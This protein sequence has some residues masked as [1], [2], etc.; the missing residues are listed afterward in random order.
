MSRSILERC[1]QRVASFGLIYLVL[2]VGSA[3]ISNDLESA[4]VQAAVR[5][6][7]LLVAVAVFYSH[8]RVEL[9]RS[10]QRLLVSAL[11]TSSAVALGTFLLAVYAV[12][13]SWW[14]SSYL[15][16]SLLSALLI[17][18]MVTS[19]PAFLVALVLGS[20]IARFNTRTKSRQTETTR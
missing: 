8:L 5:V 7:I 4:P 17:W 3:F 10:A 6:G 11:I 1:W 2:G 13:L 15:P 18:P 12:G 20:L 14:E 19:L 9:A 16:A